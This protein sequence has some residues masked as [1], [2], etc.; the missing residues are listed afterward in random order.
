MEEDY[1]I[2]VDIYGTKEAFNQKPIEGDQNHPNDSQIVKDEMDIE[3][4][5]GDN[6]DKG[7]RKRKKKTSKVWEEFDE[8]TLKDVT[9]KLNCKYCNAKLS[10]SKDDSTSHLI[11]HMKG[12]GIRLA[13]ISGSTQKAQVEELETMMVKLNV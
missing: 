11:R 7:S 13:C 10:Q 5:D 3:S 1:A 12:C 6:L 2:D 8:V 9:K 4:T